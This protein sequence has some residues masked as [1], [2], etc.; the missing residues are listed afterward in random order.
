MRWQCF[1]ADEREITWQRSADILSTGAE[2]R[3]VTGKE[4]RRREDM[5]RAAEQCRDDTPHADRIQCVLPYG[6]QDDMRAAAGEFYWA[7][8]LRASEG[9]L[10]AST[11]ALRR[12]YAALKAHATRVAGTDGLPSAEVARQQRALASEWMW[13]GEVGS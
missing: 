6:A 8:V 9:D 4:R 10:E 1:E 13:H 11:E 3:P 12:M 7:R 5:M 2:G